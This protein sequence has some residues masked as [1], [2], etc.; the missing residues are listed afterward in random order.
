YRAYVTPGE[1]P[2]PAAAAAVTA[3]AAAA[4]N[5]LE[6]RLLPALDA[7]RTAVLGLGEM[8]ADAD[9]RAARDELVVRFGQTTGPVLAKGVEDTAFYRCSRLVSLNEVG[10]DPAVFGVS[11]A[12]FHAAAGRLSRRWPA[13]LAE[14]PHDW[15]HQA[16]EWHGLARW[17]TDG[18][19][20]E[21]S[22]RAPE[23]DLEYLMWQ[24]L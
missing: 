13:T 18:A 21:A 17:I 20:A 23:P 19:A 24:T 8:T 9:Q 7:V 16:A 10:G 11:P 14:Y 1:P 22:E 3:A 4:R 2:S 12:E 5:H 15:G 6:E